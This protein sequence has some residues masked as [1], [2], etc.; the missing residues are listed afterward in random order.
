M[1]NPLPSWGPALLEHRIHAARIHEEHGTN[2]GGDVYYFESL[3]AKYEPGDLRKGGSPY[4]DPEI[5]KL[6]ENIKTSDERV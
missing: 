3:K 6:N 4:Y 1:F 2:F 5:D